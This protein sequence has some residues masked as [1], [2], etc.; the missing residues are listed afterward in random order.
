MTDAFGAALNDLEDA[1]DEYEALAD[2]VAPVETLKARLG[3]WGTARKRRE[4]RPTLAGALKQASKAGAK[5]S[6][7]TVTAD[8]SVTL[9]FGEAN[10]GDS[11]AANEWDEVL[12][13]GAASKIH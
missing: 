5:V 2:A 4:R 9:Q 6:G 11:A 13:D 1:L 8:G 7:A 10:A 12:P 3:G